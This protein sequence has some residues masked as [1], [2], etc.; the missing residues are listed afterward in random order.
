M[1]ILNTTVAGL[2]RKIREAGPEADH[3]ALQLSKISFP[4]SLRDVFTPEVLRPMICGASNEQRL[5]EKFS[6]YAVLTTA[7]D[8]IRPVM[9]SAIMTGNEGLILASRAYYASHLPP[10]R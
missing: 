7:L 9:T 1:N 4:T 2:V 6:G 8:E 3:A 10:I 5:V